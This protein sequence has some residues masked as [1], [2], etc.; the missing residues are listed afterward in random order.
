MPSAAP[1]VQQ[2]PALGKSR[3]GAPADQPGP[4]VADSAPFVHAAYSRA[5]PALATR[6][7]CA[8]VGNAHPLSG[9]GW[10]RKREPTMI[11]LK[12]LST[13]A[14]FALALPAITSTAG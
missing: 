3:S 4:I 13:A 6:G 9:L 8:T 2:S 1:I 11:S 7:N 12:I 5:L 10:R 14:V